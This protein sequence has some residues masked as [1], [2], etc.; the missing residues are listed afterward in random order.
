VVDGTGSGSCPMMGFGVSGGVKPSDWAII[1]CV[2]TYKHIYL[3]YK[4]EIMKLKLKRGHNG[5]H[6]TL[7]FLTVAA[8]IPKSNVQNKLLTNMKWQSH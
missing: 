6:W 8:T 1:V 3:Q 7:S 5:S 4:S 2:S